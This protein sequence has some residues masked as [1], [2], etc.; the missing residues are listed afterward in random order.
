MTFIQAIH[1]SRQW[2]QGFRIRK[3]EGHWYATTS[4]IMLYKLRVK[5]RIFSNLLVIGMCLGQVH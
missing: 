3:H 2:P 5:K 1:P 4:Q